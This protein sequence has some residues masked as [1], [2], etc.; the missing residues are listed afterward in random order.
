MS[1]ADIPG[2]DVRSKFISVLSSTAIDSRA[3]RYSNAGN[4]L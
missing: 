1:R 4:A 2:L 3:L